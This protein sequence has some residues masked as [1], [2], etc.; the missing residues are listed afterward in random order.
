MAQIRCLISQLSEYELQWDQVVPDNIS[1][2]FKIFPKS[3]GS[4][5][6]LLLVSMLGTCGALMGSAEVKLFETS[7]ARGNLFVLGLAPSGS[8]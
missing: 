3:Y 1:D 5:R 8:A 7:R 2:W 6:E 4:S